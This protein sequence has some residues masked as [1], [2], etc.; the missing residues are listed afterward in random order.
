MGGSRNY[1]A[2]REMLEK[3]FDKRV[4]RGSN[5]LEIALARQKIIANAIK[6]IEGEFAEGNIS[7]ENAKI[8]ID[9]ELKKL[10]KTEDDIKKDNK[11]LDKIMEKKTKKLA[12]CNYVE[13]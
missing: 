3:K 8:M 2:K 13:R 9:E 6:G 12:K 7:R 5:N 10:G 1:R 11:R 4:L